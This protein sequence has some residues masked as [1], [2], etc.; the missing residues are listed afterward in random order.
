MSDF[1][2]AM[3]DMLDEDKL[4]LQLDYRT[5]LFSEQEIARIIRQF[6]SVV[7]HMVKG[8]TAADSGVVTDE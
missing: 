4:V 7:E 6:L 8:P 3:I 1:D 5:E 2:I